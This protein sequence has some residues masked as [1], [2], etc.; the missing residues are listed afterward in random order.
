M[1]AGDVKI[2]TSGDNLTLIGDDLDNTIGVIRTANDE[3]LVIGQDGTTVTYEGVTADSHVLP[4]LGTDR[5]VNRLRIVLKGGN[6][7]VSVNGIHAN[8]AVINGGTG[9]DYIYS[10]SASF[11]NYHAKGNA[12]IDQVRFTGVDMGRARINVEWSVLVFTDFNEELTIR[13]TNKAATLPSGFHNTVQLGNSRILDGMRITTGGGIDN[14][15]IGGCEVNGN[16]HI[17]AG[18]GRDTVSLLESNFYEDI[19]VDLGKGNDGFRLGT[20]PEFHGQL[21]V[22]GRDG[23]DTYSIFATAPLFHGEVPIFDSIEVMP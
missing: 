16:S 19:K 12:G 18:A 1:L 5:S 7:D 8:R 13:S 14:I 21:E 20:Q 11:D 6:D 22:Y 3:I 9:D 15:S 4:D 17:K 23:S 10:A 2:S